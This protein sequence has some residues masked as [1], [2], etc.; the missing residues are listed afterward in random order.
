MIKSVF[1]IIFILYSMQGLGDSNRISD[2]SLILYF[3][4]LYIT[5]VHK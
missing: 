2:H 5:T 3:Y 1:I 4:K